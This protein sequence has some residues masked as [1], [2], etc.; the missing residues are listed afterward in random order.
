MNYFFSDNRKSFLYENKR[1]PPF[2]ILHIVPILIE[3]LIAAISVL[4]R[5]RLV[6]ATTINDVILICLTPG[7][8]TYLF[9]IIIYSIQNYIDPNLRNYK[10]QIYTQDIRIIVANTTII[11]IGGLTGMLL[12]KIFA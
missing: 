8:I 11:T 2:I 4:L 12:I 6:F 10:I 3:F 7:L 5:N 9:V 1:N